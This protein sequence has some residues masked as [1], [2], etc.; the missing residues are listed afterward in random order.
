[1]VDYS[2]H[3]F[4]NY[5]LTQQI[6]QD[7]AVTVSLGEHVYLKIPVVVKIFH[8]F[9][10]RN[11]Q[12]LFMQKMGIIGRLAH[13]HII[14]VLDYGLKDTTPFLV[15]DYAPN[16]TFRQYQ[17]QVMAFSAALL[18]AK[19]IGSA[20]QYA[21]HHMVIHGNLKP[22]N[23]LLGF[24]RETL[25]SDFAISNFSGQPEQNVMHV[26]SYK[27]PE[28]LQGQPQPASDQYALGCMIYEWLSGVRL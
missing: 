23:I 11:Q 16:G 12:D 8:A 5:R 15:M 7:G 25:L 14:P 6:S 28:A 21:H 26:I 22:E 24:Q 19:E 4:G 17:G 27:A 9:S 10:T 13:P 1:M 20:L 2:A 3:Q 18:H